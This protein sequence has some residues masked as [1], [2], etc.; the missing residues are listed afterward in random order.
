MTKQMVKNPDISTNLKKSAQ[1]EIFGLKTK[2]CL[3]K[4]E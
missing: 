3:G 4:T 1:M 2:A